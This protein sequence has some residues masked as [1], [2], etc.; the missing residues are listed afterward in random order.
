MDQKEFKNKSLQVP[1]YAWVI[2]A[3]SFIASVA[4]PLAQFKVP[5]IMPVLMEAFSLN[6][7]SAGMLMSVFAITG[8][9][10][11]LPA[12]MIMQKLGLKFTGLIAMSSI[13]SGS[14]LGAI[15]S[16]SET[17]L[18]SRVIEGIGMGLIAVV[19]P[20]SIAMW[21]PSEKR[22]VPMGIWAT[23][24]P[25][26]SVLMYLIAPAITTAFDWRITWWFSAIFGVAAFILVWLFLK[27]PPM[28]LELNNIPEESSNQKSFSM[29][30]A[31]S[32][33]DIWLLAFLFGLFNLGTISINTYYPTFLTEVRQ[34][35]IGSAATI[36]SITMVVVLFSAPLAGFL[37]DKIGSRKIFL[38]WP[39]LVI[40]V[41]Y[42]FPFTIEGITIPVWLGFMGV[43]GGMIPTATF[44]SAPEIMKKPELSGLGMS[45]VTMG[46]NLGM[47]TGP[48]IFAAFQA[49]YGWSI[50]GWLL[51]PFLL[52]G[53]MIGWLIKVR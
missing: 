40:A 51:I 21:F 31:L 20:A 10:L 41:M 49:S 12:G 13:I 8:L 53:F 4:A 15:S 6:L 23:W 16:S 46:Q 14:I 19:A 1:S 43:I 34:Y 36:S 24:V 18:F 50:A 27:P 52:L 11:A 25:L 7:S 33:R 29:K 30:K 47:F 42:L 2:L 44:S 28:P 35:S 45:M 9:I 17:L 22:G 37:S 3:V 39:F 26:G 48:I 32:N 38:T 5:P